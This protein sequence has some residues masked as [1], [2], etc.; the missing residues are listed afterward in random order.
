VVGVGV[1][2]V[3]GGMRRGPTVPLA[4]AGVWS[5]S[6]CHPQPPQHLHWCWLLQLALHPWHPQLSPPTTKE[7]VVVGVVAPH[8]YHPL[9]CYGVG[10]WGG[11]GRMG[12]LLHP[13]P[14]PAVQT[15]ARPMPRG[16]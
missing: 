13:H 10:P 16:G 9:G 7:P 12:L 8:P 2:V 4:V 5:P 6:S 15:L 14:G 1:G 11:K 3:K